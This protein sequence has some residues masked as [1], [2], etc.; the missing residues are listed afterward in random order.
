MGYSVRYSYKNYIKVIG[1]SVPIILEYGKTFVSRVNCFPLIRSSQVVCKL[2]PVYGY[3]SCGFVCEKNCKQQ[4]TQHIANS[5]ELWQHIEHHEWYD[6]TVR[7][8][9]PGFDNPHNWFRLSAI[10]L[11]SKIGNE[12]NWRKGAFE[13][14]FGFRSYDVYIASRRCANELMSS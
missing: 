14:G 12:L 8:A 4:K 9:W 2:Q 13:L 1:M 6:C 3:N 5:Y 10:C 11:H 7:K